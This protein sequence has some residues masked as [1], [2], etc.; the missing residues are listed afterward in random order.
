M[1]LEF[2]SPSEQDL[3]TA[4]ERDLKISFPPSELKALC[5]IIAARDAGKYQPW[6]LYDD[7]I[8]IGECFLWSGNPGFVL[9]DYLCVTPDRRNDGLGGVMLSRMREKLPDDIILCE[10]ET[11]THADDPEMAKRRVGFYR[12]HGAK[13][14]GFEAEIVGVRYQILYWS[15]GDKIIPDNIILK[16][17][18]ALYQNALTPETYRRYC[19]IP[20]NPDSLSS[21]AVSMGIK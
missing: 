6:C 10:T 7:N 19:R 11:P 2:K 21:E 5:H 3:K 9:L 15:P 13:L 4:Y 20:R 14:S 8:L 1:N 18:M 17:Y 16:E 12:R